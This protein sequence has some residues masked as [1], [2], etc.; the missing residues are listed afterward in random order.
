MTYSRHF[1]WEEAEEG[2]RTL[3]HFGAVDQI[4][5]VYLNGVYL[6]RHEGGYHPFTFD[7]THVFPLIRSIR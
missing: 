3:L 4:A 5:E 6:G 1:I 7:I 2:K